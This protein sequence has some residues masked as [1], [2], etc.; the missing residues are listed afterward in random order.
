M[1][2]SKVFIDGIQSTKRYVKTET[3]KNW[4]EFWLAFGILALGVSSASL[5]FADDFLGLWR[6]KQM[7]PPG[8]YLVLFQNNAEQRPSGGFIGSFATLDITASGYENLVVDT[9]IYKRDNAFTERVAISP[10]EPLKGVATNDRLAMRDSNWD[11]DFRSSAERVSW[12][13]KQEG[14]EAV[15][16]VIAIN[17][18]VAQDLLKIIGSIP[19]PTG[20]ELKA[21]NFF[22]TLHY[23]IEKE[24]FYDPVQRQQ[25]EPKTVIKELIPTFISRLKQANVLVRLPAF[26]QQ[27]LNERQIQLYHTDENVEANILA[28]N[29]GG[30]ISETKGDYLALFNANVGGQKSSLN[31]SQKTTVKI[32]LETNETLY[33][34][35]II[36]RTHQGTGV[37]PDHTNNN[38][39]RIVVPSNAKLIS[40]TF[41]GSDRF[42]QINIEPAFNKTVFGTHV[43]TEPGATSQLVL[44]YLVKL[45]QN[46]QS[47]FYQKQSGTLAEALEVSV[48]DRTVFNALLSTDATVKF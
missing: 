22:T 10:P 19:L 24:Y 20:D 3:K 21:E 18:T 16:G 43:D 25:N 15:D 33:H 39:L 6:L 1:K 32:E 28:A 11:I 45:D 26:I 34:R 41:N 9:N 7:I 42:D 44:E 47:L 46:R 31:V 30:A 37:W 17:A 36:E 13:Y 23:I 38:Y 2:S 27:E 48:G 8:H 5:V 12:F 14:G 35:V 29:W 4:R 40:A